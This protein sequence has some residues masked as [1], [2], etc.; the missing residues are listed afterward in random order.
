MQKYS[1]KCLTF[2]SLC[3]WCDTRKA[4]A[5]TLVISH[6]FRHSQK[7]KH[8][9]RSE[10]TAETTH[11]VFYRVTSALCTILCLTDEPQGKNLTRYLLNFTQ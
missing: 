5:S 7:E 6:F 8:R 2:P 3:L 4:E 10:Q 9:K 11:T 1:Q